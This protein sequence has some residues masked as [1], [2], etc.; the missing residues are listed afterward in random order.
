MKAQPR[1]AWFRRHRVALLGDGT[2]T[3]SAIACSNKGLIVTGDSGTGKTTAIKQLGKHHEL[4]ARRRRTGP[5]PFLPVVYLTVPP[6]ATPKILAAEF[7]RFLALPLPRYFNQINITNAVC[8]LLCRL[9]TDLVLVDE[10]HNV[11]LATR[12]GA[13]SSDQLKYLAE[14]LPAT[15]VYAGIDVAHV[16]LFTGIRGRQIAG[17][18][19]TINTTSFAYGTPTQRAQWTALIATLEQS[20]RLHQHRRGTL[21][22]L[23]TYLY[24]RTS[25]MIG[26]LSHL[27]RAAAIDAIFDGTE[28]ISRNSLDRVILDHAAESAY[29]QPPGHKPFRTTAASRRV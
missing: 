28:R 8:D 21:T 2:F 23:A 14:R 27:I 1:H 3:Q 20:L 9:G 18:F 26:S 10:I 13:D 4:L 19:P 24:E 15:F 16:G 17:R 12:V 5:G 11:N 6:A 22:R 25:G 29:A 7:A